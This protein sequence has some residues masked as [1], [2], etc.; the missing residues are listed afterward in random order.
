MAVTLLVPLPFSNI[1][2]GTII[3]LV[4]LAY[5]EGDGLLLVF[6]LVMSLIAFFGLP[7]AVWG[8]AW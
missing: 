2:P 1:V 7:A 6:A 3:T 8:H 5:L 4:A